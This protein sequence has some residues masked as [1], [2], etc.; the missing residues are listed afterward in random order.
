M[1]RVNALFD[2]FVDVYQN[3][4]SPIEIQSSLNRYQNA[5]KK[6][7]TDLMKNELK[8]WN[9]SLKSQDAK[10]FWRNVD[11]KGNYKAE[12]QYD[13]PSI[14]EF[15]QFYEELY[16]NKDPNELEAIEKLDT[17]VRIPELDNPITST[18]MLD[19]YKEM[20]KPGYD[21]NLPVLGILISQFSVILL[22]I[23]NAMFFISY[24]ASLAISLLSLIPKKGNLLLTKNYRGI[25][26]MKILACLYDRIIT[27]RLKPWLKFHIDQTAF[28]AMKSTLIHI[29]TIRLLIAL[30]KKK[31]KVLYIA[32]MDIEKAF[33]S[34]SR[35]ILL[36][37]LIK[38]GISKCMLSSLKA[39]YS[40][41]M[42]IIK[43]KGVI[44]TMFRMLRGIRQGAPSSVLLFNV[45]IDGLFEYLEEQC[46][47]DEILNNIHTLIHADDTIVISTNRAQFIEKC[48]Q[49]KRFF[50]QNKLKLNKGKLW[51]T[52][53]NSNDSDDKT[54]IKI[55]GGVIKYSSCLE[56]LGVLISDSG[57]IDLD[58]K[59]FIETKQANVSIKYRNYCNKNRNAPLSAKL[60]VLD[61]CVSSSIIYACETWGKCSEAAEQLYRVGLRVA[62]DIR[63]NINN[64]ILYVE[65]GR[66]PLECK[67]KKLQH[68]F[69]TYSKDY[70]ME[71][72]A[73]AIA[74]VLSMALQEKVHIVRYYKDLD[75]EFESPESCQNS[76]RN[77]FELKWRNKFTNERDENSR[78]G[79][80][81]S[82]N[83][84]L[85]PWVPI[86]QNIMESERKIITRFRTG[87]HSLNIEI[88]RYSNIQRERRLCSCKLAVQNIWHV[89]M[90]CPSTRGVNSRNYESLKEIFEDND[91]HSNLINICIRLKIPLGRI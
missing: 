87:S 50:D 65:S 54:H 71:N 3:S 46:E 21:Y 41:T 74:K 28:Q 30:V 36:Q 18:E 33:D 11:W 27:N 45:F 6:I 5:R 49:T 80:Y 29:F 52:V 57:S 25:Q 24:P 56:Y 39:L 43:F 77:N 89:F 20:K 48:K 22:A 47:P 19:A 90:Q 2:N 72:P 67:I 37:K 75:T 91:I 15:E 8:V 68:K 32:S 83:P 38:I 26:M 40:Y 61:T 12:K 85:T 51:F 1:S 81:F 70:M 66:H 9:D 42:C 34:V 13:S 78:L 63:S 17:D 14:Q 4:T 64:E 69:W 7:T 55:E 60:D 62:L 73:S 16:D 31:K 23:L 84:D 44:S 58:I 10:S 35:Y 82:V 86:P 76:L 88:M 59:N 79:T 53:I